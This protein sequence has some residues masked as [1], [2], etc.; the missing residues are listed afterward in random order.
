MKKIISIYRLK[1]SMKPQ[2][3]KGKNNIKLLV[4]NN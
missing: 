3:Y 2:K 1:K 4:E